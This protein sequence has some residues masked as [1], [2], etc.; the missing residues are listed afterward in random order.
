MKHQK[1]AYVRVSSKTQNVSRQV[2][3]VMKLGVCKSNIIVEKASGK[4]FQRTEYLKMLKLLK[5]GDILYINSVDRLGRD[6]DGI[7]MEWHRLTKKLN[8]TI[9]VIDSPVLDTDKPPVTL[10]E[11][12]LRDLTLITL[13]F[14]AE[15]E[16]QDIKK[17]QK[18]GIIT[19]KEEG[20]ILGRPKIVRTEKEIY[21]V[22]AW[23]NGIITVNE[24]MQKLNLKKSA[25]YK[26][27]NEVKD[28]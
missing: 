5:E 28:F 16:L 17:R 23:Q 26:L 14:Y 21:A 6:Y 15:Q 2:K 8:I 18:S 7:I 3:E 19:A 13:A 10:I 22:K 24:A 12:Y 4:N 27:A 20:K 25:F 11:K 1:Y 9:I